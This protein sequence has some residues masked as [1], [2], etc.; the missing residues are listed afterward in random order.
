MG[1]RHKLLAWRTFSVESGSHWCLVFER[2][3]GEGAV[4]VGNIVVMTMTWAWSR[5]GAANDE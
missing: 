3:G 5:G 4:G 1:S 2:W